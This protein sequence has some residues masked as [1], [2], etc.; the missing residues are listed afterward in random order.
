PAER[1]V[2]RQRLLAMLDYEFALLQQ[3]LQATRGDR[4]EFFVYANTVATRSYSRRSD[5]HGWMG[6]R[7]QHAPGA[8]PSEIILHVWMRDPEAVREQEAIG[9]LGVNLLHGAFYRR[10][11]PSDLIAGLLDNLMRE[12]IEIDLIRFDGPAFAGVD[13]RLMS[14]QLVEQ[15]FTDATMFTAQGEVVQ[16]ADLLYKR[17]ILIER[18]S[19]RPITNLT[20]TIVETA[21]ARFG[22][23]DE[24]IVLLEMTLRQLQ[25]GDRIDHTDFLARVDT[26]GTLGYTVMISNYLRYHR[27]VPFLRRLTSHRIGFA[28]GLR[29][30]K[31]LFDERFYTD[32]PGGILQALGQ[33]FQGDVKLYV[34]PAID[35]ESKL[36][37]NPESYE[38]P[39]HLMHLYGH[40]IENQLIETVS[41]P[42][43]LLRIYSRDVLEQIR[44]G[45]PRW[46]SLVPPPVAAMIKQRHY[47]GCP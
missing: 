22:V 4:T 25:T 42:E 33:L 39:R 35:P 43:E 3:R 36:I 6:V 24:P 10:A 26:L 32:V 18:G 29:N 5:G 23:S 19:F 40:L 7:F 21:R 28:M 34:T 1:Y 8:A 45:D 38:P 17:P 31:E 12:R 27:L 46:E 41:V 14:L 15:G 47:F 37:V 30:L 11:N 16:P 9:V 13:N 20:H 44:R 2:S